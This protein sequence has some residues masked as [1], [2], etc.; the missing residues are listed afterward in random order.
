MNPAHCAA[1]E[2]ILPHREDEAGR[3]VD[4]GRAQAKPLISAEK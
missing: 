1:E 3:G 2:L 4:K